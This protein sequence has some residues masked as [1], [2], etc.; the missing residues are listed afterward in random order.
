MKQQT[1]YYLAYGGNTEMDFQFRGVYSSFN[2]AEI[3]LQDG[4]FTMYEILKSYE[5]PA[6]FLL[7]QNPW[8]HTYRALVAQDAKEHVAFTQRMKAQS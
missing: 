7:D 5:K 8:C 4:L 6:G 1:T 3:V 2:R